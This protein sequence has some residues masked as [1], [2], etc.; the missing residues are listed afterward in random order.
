MRNGL[1]Q[2]AVISCFLFNT[3]INDLI[4]KLKRT[5]DIQCLAFADDIAI[6]STNQNID[7]ANMNVNKAMKILE[8]L[9][10]E[11]QMTMNTEKTVYQ[12][13]NIINKATVNICSI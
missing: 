2:G 7:T 3:M 10:D 5:P 12:L 8:N 1:P 9:C 6:F 4:K 13:F 11:N